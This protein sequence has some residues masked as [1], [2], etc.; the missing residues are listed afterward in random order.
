M[1]LEIWNECCITPPWL[2]A[3][4]ILDRSVPYAVRV[5]DMQH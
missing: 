4:Y 3:P 2:G 1:I 5:Y